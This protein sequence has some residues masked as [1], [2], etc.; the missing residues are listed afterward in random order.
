MLLS[1]IFDEFFSAETEIQESLSPA[2]DTVHDYIA[3]QVDEETRPGISANIVY[4][5]KIIWEGNFGQTSKIN[6]TKPNG[7][8]IYR[9]YD[10]QYFQ[11]SF[12]NFT[13]QRFKLFQSW[14]RMGYI[15]FRVFVFSC[16]SRNHKVKGFF[17]VS[18]SS[19]FKKRIK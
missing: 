11:G 5:N 17:R 7:N 18:F 4:K 3:S 9:F 8:T 13:P 16:V 6:T 10:L 15:T 1:T 12:I 2:F 14:L 19:F